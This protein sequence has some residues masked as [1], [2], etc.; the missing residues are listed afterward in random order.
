MLD[1][2]KHVQVERLI[3]LKLVL[4]PHRQPQVQ[5]QVQHLNRPVVV[6]RLQTIFVVTPQMYYTMWLCL[7][8]I[9]QMLEINLL[10]QASLV[11]KFYK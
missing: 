2:N 8:L 7:I 4:L 9:V 5:A 6:Q 11:A 1:H 3:V 10:A